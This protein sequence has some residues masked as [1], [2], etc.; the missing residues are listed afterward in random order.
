MACDTLSACLDAC[1]EGCPEPDFQ[2]C[3]VDGQDFCNACTAA[4]YDVDLAP[5]REPCDCP[6]PV[7]ELVL[8]SAFQ[9]R[10]ECVLKPEFE[11]ES[12]VAFTVAEAAAWFDCETFDRIPFEEGSEVLV[13]AVF[14]QQPEATLGAAVYDAETGVVTLPF[15]AP[16]YCGGPAPSATILYQ[17]VRLVPDAEYVVT[18]CVH[19]RCTEFF[20]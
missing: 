19:T 11:F 4:C 5:N 17:R 8:S 3:G 9:V 16:Q 13:R 7:G 10:S 2:L 1:G 12:G 18:T 15:T 20:P 6:A 14:P